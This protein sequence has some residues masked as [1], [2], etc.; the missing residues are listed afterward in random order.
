MNELC[1]KAGVRCTEKR[2]KVDELLAADEVF[3]TGTAAEIIAVTKVDAKVIS[4][5]EGP[6]TKRLREAFRAAVTGPGCPE[7]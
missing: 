3:L 1:P 4:K 5:G 2:F 7:D 6:V